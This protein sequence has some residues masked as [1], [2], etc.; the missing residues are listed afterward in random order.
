MALL[1]ALGDLIPSVA[2]AGIFL[3]VCV[4]SLILQC[5]LKIFKSIF[6]N[7]MNITMELSLTYLALITLVLEVGEFSYDTN[8]IIGLITII[9]LLIA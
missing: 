2:S 6:M 7:T 8:E 4:V 3:G 5:P 1:I 9:I